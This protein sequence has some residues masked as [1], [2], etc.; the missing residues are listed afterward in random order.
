MFQTINKFAKK[1]IPIF[2]G[3]SI[4]IFIFYYSLSLNMSNAFLS[5][6]NQKEKNDLIELTSFIKSNNEKIPKNIK[7]LTFDFDASLFLIMKDY[8]N[9][10]LVPVSFWTSKT[11]LDIEKDLISTFKFLKLTKKDFLNFFEN[12]KGSWRYKN[13]FTERFFDRV[14]LANQLKTFNNE[15]NYSNSEIDFIKNNNPLITH[16]LIIPKDE[17]LRLSDK[18]DQIDQVIEPDLVIINNQNEI[19]NKSQ[20]NSNVYCNILQNESYT[21]YIK[22]DFEDLCN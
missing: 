19:L 18:F 7:S 22:K 2:A 15:M 11:T 1:I 9:F 14:Y 10:N 5:K 4:L 6:Y 21:L 3:I 20:I 13:K 8:N 17:F 16:Q 12:K